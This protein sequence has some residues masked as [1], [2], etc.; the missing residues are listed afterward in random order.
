MWGRLGVGRRL[1]P[2]PQVLGTQTTVVAADEATTDGEVVGGAGAGAAMA[3]PALSVPQCALSLATDGCLL[4]TTTVR[5]EWSPVSGANHYLTN[6]NG[7]YAT[8]TN[9]T[10]DLTIKD[11]SDYTLEVVAIG[12]DS[13]ASAT[14]TQNV[15]VA[16]IPIA[17]NEI[18]WMGTTASLNDEWF[19]IKNNTS[20][21]LD[22]SQWA[23]NAKDGTPNV[24]M[25]GTIDPH[26]YI[27]FERTNDETV[28]DVL[29]HA[30]TTGA[31]N[32][33]GDQLTLSRDS[34][35]FDQTPD[36]AWVAGA[37]STRQTMERYSS[38]ESGTDPSNWGT[39]LGYIKNGTDAAG[40]P[41]EG[42]PGAQ[43]SVSTLINKGQDITSNLT[44]T[45]DEER[46]VVPNQLWVDASSTLVIEPGVTIQFYSG[47]MWV[48]GA[49][50]ARGTQENP[51]IFN[52]FSEKRDGDFWIDNATGTSTF[53]YAHFEN[54]NNVFAVDGGVLEIS[55]SEFV[56]TDGGVSAYGK[57][58]RVF[59]E[60]TRFASSTDDT[61]GVY[62]GGVVSIAS[63]TI[64]NQID[65][66]A[67][68]VYYSSLIMS[69]TT[70]DGVH[71]GNGIGAYYSLVS[72]A[73]STV[74]N[75]ESDALWLSNSTTTI[76]N[77]VVQG[78]VLND[79]DGVSGISI[80]GG[81]AAITNTAVSGFTGGIGIAVSEPKE[82]VV[83]TG[84]EVTWNAVGVAMYP[85][86]A[87]VVSD[88]S[89]VHDNGTSESDNI[90]AW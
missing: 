35:I 8:T 24:A 51:V 81:M 79:S 2:A 73:S 17:I 77:T 41:I 55:D 21:T 82:P 4:A 61:I 29:A 6:K 85:D 76:A 18:A 23:L 12:S 3:A 10:L 88:V 43:N 13:N 11:F 25:K 70:I 63:S 78:G 49:V 31:L 45:P 62:N 60:N 64:E 30:T 71:D 52:S 20:H 27:I 16:T 46:Y 89:S 80:D 9:T 40:K 90:V 59:I 48:N 47:E 32:N 39:N 75:T 26:A 72:I 15:S 57:N 58:S 74:S 42:T 19:E 84:G 33:G 5:F 7:E 1:S 44:L 68:G 69:S 22:L 83:I 87:A 28:K 37:T 67:I 54:M 50:L 65:D 14:S 34:V 53:E 86:G 66:D 36:G 56:N 38:R